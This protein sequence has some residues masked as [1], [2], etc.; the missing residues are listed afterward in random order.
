MKA[1]IFISLV[2]SAFSHQFP[3]PQFPEGNAQRVRWY[4]PP[5]WVGLQERNQRSGNLNLL[6]WVV[7]MLL[8]VLKEDINFIILDSKHG[9]LLL[10]R[11]ALSLY[12]KTKQ[13]YRLFQWKIFSLCFKNIYY[14]NLR[15]DRAKGS[16]AC[17]MWRN[18]RDPWRMF[19]KYCWIC[20]SLYLF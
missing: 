13:N 9:C 12:S 8:F 17:K 2:A 15:K 16:L 18:A 1:I 7:R 10:Q 11:E 20:R 3:K 5:Q 14:T 6:C 19:S 4:L